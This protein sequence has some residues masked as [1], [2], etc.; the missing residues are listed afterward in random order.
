M[1]KKRIA[2]V[3]SSMRS[4]GA[5]RVMANLANYWAQ[6]GHTVT[7]ITFVS[8]DEAPF[9]EL[10]SAIQYERLDCLNLH[11]SSLD[12]LKSIFFSSCSCI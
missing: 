6:Q 7:L 2:L 11:A 5:E 10:H 1:K 8:K 12:Y 3:I 9:Y 4:G